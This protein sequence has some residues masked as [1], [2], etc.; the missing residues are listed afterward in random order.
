MLIDRKGALILSMTLAMLAACSDS[1]GFDAATPNAFVSEPTPA[2]GV[3]A[4]PEPAAETPAPK[5]LR[6]KVTQR[7]ASVRRNATASVTIATTRGASCAIDVEYS[8]GS[9]TAKGLDPK[10]ANSK[11]VIT[12]KWKVGSNTTR[13]TWPITIYCDLG[14]RSGSVSTKFKVT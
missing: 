7:T 10:K 14:D 13:G 3:E 11:G 9:A 1:G 5:P 4:I 8:S 2:V 12:W 6:V